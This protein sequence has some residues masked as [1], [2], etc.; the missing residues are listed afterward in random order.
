MIFLLIYII[1]EITSLYV[2]FIHFGTTEI[3]ALQ[4]HEFHLRITRYYFWQQSLCK[5]LLSVQSKVQPWQQYPSCYLP[6]NRKLQERML[7]K[8]IYF[9]HTHIMK[10][11]VKYKIY[12]I[13]CYQIYIL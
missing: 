1:I 2:I 12:N 7:S 3:K 8:N 11:I 13:I 5:M 9:T 6:S 4:L 10:N